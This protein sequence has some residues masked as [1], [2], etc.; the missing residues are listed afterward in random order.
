MTKRITIPKN[1]HWPEWYWSAK[2][3]DMVCRCTCGGPLD[4]DRSLIANAWANAWYDHIQAIAEYLSS[5]NAEDLRSMSEEEA[6]DFLYSL[7]E[8]YY[9]W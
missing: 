2:E 6:H 5:E 7:V 1:R 8:L 4:C 9:P 3:Q